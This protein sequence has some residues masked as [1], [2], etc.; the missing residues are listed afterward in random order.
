MIDIGCNI[1]STSGPDH[2]SVPDSE[3]AYRGGMVREVEL[4]LSEARVVGQHRRKATK[5]EVK[6][7]KAWVDERREKGLPPWVGSESRRNEHG[8]ITLNEYGGLRSSKTLRNWAD[9]YCT[10][11]KHLKE[12]TYEKVRASLCQYILY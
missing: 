1:P 8:F 4:G 11:K 3:P 5:P 12:F 7:F 6:V 10:S 2:W 9:E